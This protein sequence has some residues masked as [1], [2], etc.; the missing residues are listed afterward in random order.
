MFLINSPSPLIQSTILARKK[1]LSTAG[2]L[3]ST[4]SINDKILHR[5]VKMPISRGHLDQ[6]SWTIHTKN[7]PTHD[8]LKTPLLTVLLASCDVHL[9]DHPSTP[10]GLAGMFGGK[11]C[12]QSM[13][14]S[15]G[16]CQLWINL[17]FEFTSKVLS[18][19]FSHAQM[20]ITDQELLGWYRYWLSP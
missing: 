6:I 17:F 8:T 10:G 1:V 11:A 2:E 16:M 20:V 13:Q 12:C 3:P 19:R 14:T 7:K 4:I 18:E 9:E 15:P 5:Q